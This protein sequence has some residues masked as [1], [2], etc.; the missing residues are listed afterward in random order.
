MSRHGFH[1]WTES[2]LIAPP[3]GLDTFDPF[4][5]AHPADRAAPAGRSPS[6]SLPSPLSADTRVLSKEEVHHG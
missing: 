3:F 4:Y 1:D 5:E 2:V 6:K